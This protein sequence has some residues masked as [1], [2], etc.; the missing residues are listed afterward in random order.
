MV[1]VIPTFHLGLRAQITD[2]D[3]IVNYVVR[4]V[5]MNPGSITSLHSEDEVSV[6]KIDG[7][8]ENKSELLATRFRDGLQAILDRYAT[9][10][11]R[12]AVATEYVENPDGKSVTIKLSIK[13]T[14]N[15]KLIS[16]DRDFL[17][18]QTKD[19]RTMIMDANKQN[20][21]KSQTTKTG[22]IKGTVAEYD[23]S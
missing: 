18:D 13:A 7:D 23:F 2:P 12:F 15:G 21:D 6:K 16:Y 1:G 4:H 20:T 5:L 10:D 11:N 22:P 8:F 14:Y 3:S 17:V 9:G 19:F